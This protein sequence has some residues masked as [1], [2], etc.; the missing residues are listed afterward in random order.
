M[1][2]AGAGRSDITPPVGIAH[3]GWGA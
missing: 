2:I 3:A 1:L